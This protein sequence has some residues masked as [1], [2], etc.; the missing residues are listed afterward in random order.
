MN[1]IGRLKKRKGIRKKLYQN[2]FYVI[3]N[4]VENLF[5]STF[6]LTALFS[7]N[8]FYSILLYSILLYSILLY[9]ILLYSI[10]L[11]SIL[12]YSILLYSILICP[13]FIRAE[14]L[15][16]VYHYFLS[17]WNSSFHYSHFIFSWQWNIWITFLMTSS[18]NWI[19]PLVLL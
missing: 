3:Y 14:T 16:S 11:Y 9:S 13:I 8:L 7:S 1:E 12:L 4:Y 17:K 15:G 6:C 5:V 18:Q 2:I 10:L 19:F